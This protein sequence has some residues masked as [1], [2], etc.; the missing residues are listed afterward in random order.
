MSQ[1]LRLSTFMLLL[2][3][4]CSL[5]S[6][7]GKKAKNNESQK[8]EPYRPPISQIED[9]LS[10]QNVL[11]EGNQV[12]PNYIA[13]IVVLQP[14][15]FKYCTGFLTDDGVVATAANCIPDR[16]RSVGQDC[17]QDVFL[18]FPRTSTRPSERVG[19]LEVMQVSQLI[20]ND[21]IL[22]RDDVA[23]L[24]VTPT[25]AYRKKARISR[26]GIG[27]SKQFYSWTI[28]QQDDRTAIIKRSTCEAI[29]N[30][31][32][33][34]LVSNDSSP[35]MVFSDCGSANGI[36]GAPV[37]DR[38]GN[39]RSIISKT[40]DANLRR[41]LESTGLLI[42]GLKHMVHASNFACAPTPED[43]DMLDERECSKDLNILRVDKARSDMLST[44]TLFANMKKE[45]EDSISKLSPHVR[46]QVKM[47]PQG[48]TQEADI[49]PK[50]FKPLNDWL[51][52][53][54]NRNI[55]VGDVNIPTIT[56]RRTMDSFGRIKG[57]SVEGPIKH[58]SIQYSLKN[59]RSSRRASILMWEGDSAVQTY[60]SI[61]EDCR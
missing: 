46:F 51:S 19:C 56:F 43:S 45:L 13:K 52:T 36:S 28:D 18:F 55:Y 47:I 12:C 35:N 2:V 40:M 22:W 14:S 1:I 37:I 44:V 6:S 48:D 49:T 25:V 30:N 33:N 9:F 34:P 41:Y 21:P 59:L 60:S 54:G 17:S 57:T 3:G 15:G 42:D 10:K 61:T 24:K 50:C 26:E 27:N 8:E 4:L 16:I 20:E 39:V 11:C 38:L 53:F 5:A 32:I 31:Y 7:C 29:H 58:Y 23:F